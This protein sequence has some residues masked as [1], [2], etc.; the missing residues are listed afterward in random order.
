V[1]RAKST[2]LSLVVI[3]IIIIFGLPNPA[4]ETTLIGYAQIT[5]RKKTA[6]AEEMRKM[7]VLMMRHTVCSGETTCIV[8]ILVYI[9]ATIMITFHPS[10]KNGRKMC[11]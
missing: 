4:L 6:R 5:R 3:I 8:H 9:H 10:L 2:L 11:L 7:V 1:A